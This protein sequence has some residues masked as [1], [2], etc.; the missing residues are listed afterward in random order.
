VSTFMSTG[1]S[2]KGS[3]KSCCQPGE[4]CLNLP[5]DAHHPGSI[6][7]LEKKKLMHSNNF[8]TGHNT[9]GLARKCQILQACS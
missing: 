6:R 9:S 2:F 1:C 3:L 5:R 4:I 7:T 8:F